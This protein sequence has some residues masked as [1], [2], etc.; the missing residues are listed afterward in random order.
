[1]TAARYCEWATMSEGERQFST[2]EL[3]VLDCMM[4]GLTPPEIADTV[5]FS[6]RTMRR[7]RRRIRHKLGASTDAQAVVVGLEAGL[8]GRRGEK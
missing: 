1:M 4:N 8:L 7:V 6:G 2:R 3:E 5:G